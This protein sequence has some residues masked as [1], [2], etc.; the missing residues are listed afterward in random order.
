MFDGFHA[1]LPVTGC[2]A[3][4]VVSLKWR[5]VR[6]FPDWTL[7]VVAL[8]GVLPDLC[9]PHISLED[10]YESW[11]HTLLFLVLLFPVCAGMTWW[12]PKGTRVRV[13]VVGWVATALHLA[14]D[15]VSG[16]IPW[17]Q[18]WSEMPIGDYHIRPDDWLFFDAGFIVLALV[19][20]WLRHRLEGLAYV[21]S[22]KSGHL[23]NM[24]NHEKH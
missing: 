2:L 19:G 5:G 17:L 8:F 7:P 22:L 11:S 21:Q 10:R 6:V 18:P 4:E 15:A 3:I 23:E 13:A 1:L 12:F 20:W 24:R 14:A 9:S 16:G